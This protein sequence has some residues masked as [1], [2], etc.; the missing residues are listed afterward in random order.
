MIY[1]STLL[2]AVA[3]SSMA[4]TITPQQ[5]MS[6]VMP[7]RTSQL[8]GML[9]A[10]TN[11]SASQINHRRVAEE[12]ALASAWKPGDVRKAL[13]SLST[14]MRTKLSYQSFRVYDAIGAIHPTC[15]P[16]MLAMLKE[17]A[18]PASDDFNSMICSIGRMGQSAKTAIPWLMAALSDTQIGTN[19]KAAIRV[20]LANIAK[21][22]KHDADSILDDLK[23]AQRRQRCI[24]T[25]VA[26]RSAD[27]LTDAMLDEIAQALAEN[28]KGQNAGKV[29]D[30][31]MSQCAIIL[32]RAGARGAT[33]KLQLIAL[34]KAAVRRHST[35]A[36]LYGLALMELAPEEGRA[37]LPLLLKNLPQSLRKGL[38]DHTGAGAFALLSEYS[39]LL[40]TPKASVFV[41]RLLSD[42]DEE[43]RL[44]ALLLLGNGGLAAK[45][46][47][48]E[49]LQ[50]F[51]RTKE[52]T[53]R[54]NL[55]YLLGA[56]TPFDQVH[57]LKRALRDEDHHPTRSQLQA[58]INAILSASPLS[59]SPGDNAGDH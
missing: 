52:P 18:D 58:S 55:A 44:G 11:E 4:C 1:L 29:S 37:A 30:A 17:S 12:L 43:I 2:C 21:P 47:V 59:D 5:P 40:L 19:T 16:T 53:H 26:T 3:A 42:Q 45:E 35:A 10:P 6:S 54:L 13:A 24:S 28:D 48:P 38:G 15:I 25:L 14:G 8:L 49:V 34:Q 31:F 7:S 41:A 36:I 39:Y 22:S 46:A 56:I 50:H 33:A 23:N 20:A 9:V 57:L 51:H 32:A 27:W